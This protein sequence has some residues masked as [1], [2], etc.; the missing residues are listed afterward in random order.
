VGGKTVIT[1][2]IKQV[3]KQRTGN[4]HGRHKG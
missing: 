1:R 3:W 4:S 2:R